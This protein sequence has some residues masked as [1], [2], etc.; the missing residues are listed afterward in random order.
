[1][2]CVVSD[3]C[4]ESAPDGLGLC[5]GHWLHLPPF[6]RELYWCVFADGQ[7]RDDN[8]DK[9]YDE[10]VTQADRWMEENTSEDVG[11][12]SN[13]PKPDPA[14]LYQ[15]LNRTAE[16][17][18]ITPR[19]ST[20]PDPFGTI[21]ETQPATSGGTSPE[22]TDDGPQDINADRWHDDGGSPGPDEAPPEN[23]KDSA[24]H[25]ESE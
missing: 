17:G 1:M 22:R 15:H 10:A 6:I 19:P 21:S 12:F 14:K 9:G 4:Q 11:G 8:A 20:S 7:P 5:R 3:G 25:A 24:G 16:S 2:Q 13:R 23:P 18:D